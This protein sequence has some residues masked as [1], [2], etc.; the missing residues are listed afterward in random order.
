MALFTDILECIIGGLFM[1]GSFWATGI[2]PGLAFRRGPS[3]AISR[4]GR[5][6][7][8]LAGMAV[9]IDGIQRP[10][11]HPRWY[12]AMSLIAIA[13]LVLFLS[14][15]LVR[16]QM[17]RAGWNG[18]TVAIDFGNGLPFTMLGVR[19]AFFVTVAVMV[20]FGVGPVANSTAKAGIIACV[21]TLFAVAIVYGALEQHYLKVG[22]ATKV[23]VPSHKVREQDRGA[24]SV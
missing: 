22:R 5:V 6:I 1:C 15:K 8:F 17:R 4:T 21:L 20:T 7:L 11:G 10:L 14:S 19:V 3:Y 16:A 23:D 18:P 2:R 9:F 12:V 24:D 13:A